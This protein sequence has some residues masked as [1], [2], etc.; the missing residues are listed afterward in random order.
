MLQRG[1]EDLVFLSMRYETGEMAHVHLSWLS[2]R[3]ERRLTIV[4]SKKMVEFDDTS[5]DMLRIYDKGYDAPATFTQY[6][7]FLTLR[8]G[9]VTIPQIPME[10]P[11][12]LQLREL[13]ACIREQR[14]SLTDAQSGLRVV[15]ILAAA[16]Q[17]LAED[18]A[19]VSL[20]T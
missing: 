2:P 6:A 16:Q 13:I 14:P 4:G 17:S 15:S 20:L 5:S 19:P 7:E 12:R 3:K 11:L 18:G 10:E 9:D 8:D 1:V